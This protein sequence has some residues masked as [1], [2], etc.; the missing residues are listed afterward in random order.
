MFRLFRAAAP[1]LL[2]LLAAAPLLVPAPAPADP[3]PDCTVLRQAAG[4]YSKLA[5]HFS[6]L[7][8]VVEQPEKTQDQ[9]YAVKQE[10]AQQA[11]ALAETLRELAGQLQSPD[12]KSLY[13]TDAE[14]FDKYADTVAAN[15][16][17]EDISPIQEAYKHNVAAITAANNAFH[18]QCN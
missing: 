7:R 12:L 2:P 6:S 5:S 15:L 17:S 11:R 10:L 9:H 8:K 16:H 4:K 13:L 14:T 3:N 1:A 18:A